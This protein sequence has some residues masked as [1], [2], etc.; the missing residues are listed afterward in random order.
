VKVLLLS[1]FH[2]ELVRGGAQQICYELF[3]GLRDVEG[4]TPF[5]LAAVDPTMPELYKTGAR[6]T[7]FDGRPDEFVFLSNSYDY[8]WHKLPGDSLADAYS[9]F[10][11]LV[12]PDVVHFHHFLLFG[13]DFLT[14]TRRVLPETRIV[15]TFHEF[16]SICMANGQMVRT[17]DRSICD[18]ASPVRCHQ[19]FPAITP[20][21]FFMRQ[22]WTQRHFEAVDIF[23]T[24]SRFMIDIFARSGID[25]D[26]M[27]HVANAHGSR[28]A[29]SAPEVQPASRPRFGLLRRWGA[30]SQSSIDARRRRAVNGAGRRLERR[31]RFGFFGQMIDNK[32]VHVILEAVGILRT[33]GFTDFVIELNGGNLR[34]ASEGRRREIEAFLEREGEL[35]SEQRV[36]IATGAYEVGQLAS[37]MGRI[38]W[39]LVPSVWREAFCLVVSEAWAFGKPVIC[40]NVGG[41]A[42][43]VQDGD[44][45]LVF[46]VGDARA[47]A[48]VIRRACTE[49]GLWERTSRGI[50]PPP[51]RSVMVS[52][53]LELYRHG[54]SS[55][56][57]V[58]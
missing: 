53:F 23:T 32:G 52:E 6:I 45:G 40:S 11:R 13:L 3:E 56:T 14:L 19:C 29:S 25:V 33:D 57:A 15:L 17:T 35:P 30:R 47:L 21:Y 28:A 12:R 38:D 39:V 31:N 9:E 55:A 26:R 2:P 7:G 46:P 10:L 42:E 48:A 51:A 44:N 58:A 37:L 27:V 16:L 36:V 5:L 24:P 4:V 54:L 20:E 43:R 34:F 22:L 41:M 8:F 50:A 18:R 49:K 1:L